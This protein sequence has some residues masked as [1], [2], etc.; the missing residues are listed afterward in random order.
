MANI[1]QETV[2]GF[3][4]EWSRFDQSELSA[5][6]L[7]EIGQRYFSLLPL[8]S[9]PPTMKVMDVGC[10]SGR[11]AT[12]VAPAVGELHLVDPSR[13]ALDVARRN[14][15]GF[16]NVTFHESSVDRLP[17]ADG[18]MD[19]VYSL[20]VLHHVPDTASAIKSC[21]RKVAPGGR[22]LV[23]LYYRF[24]NRPV[25][26]RAVWKVSD[27]VRRGICRLPFRVKK[28]VTDLIAAVVYW[29]LARTARLLARLGRNPGLF[30]L[31]IYR[32]SSFYTMRTDALDR[33][34]TRLEQRFTKKEIQ[35]MMFAAGLVDV[36]FRDD[37][38]YWCAIGRRP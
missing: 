34:G 33:F 14:L 17:V 20:G 1:D 15:D 8:E 21:V 30:P 3:G 2:D 9:L 29:P 7:V 23:Y 13:S 5:A 36:R 38:P 12:L 19:L 16:G 25:W 10:G 18:S 32:D 28:I 22:F 27:L 11:W 26:F 4:D 24:D 6:E 35:D 37:E 31:S